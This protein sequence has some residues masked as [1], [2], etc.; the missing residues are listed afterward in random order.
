VLLTWDDAPLAA[1]VHP[2]A[3]GIV[4]D[5]EPNRNPL[6]GFALLLD[7]VANQGLVA[8]DFGQSV[9]RSPFPFNQLKSPYL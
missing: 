4:K 6:T 8:R 2:L 1:I 9:H 7:S 3:I 5:G